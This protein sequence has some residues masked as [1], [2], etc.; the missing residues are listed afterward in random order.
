MTITTAIILNAILM[1]GII[2][3]LAR[4]IHLPFRIE[5]RLPKLD[6][7]VYVPGRDEEEELSRAA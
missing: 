4:F 7:A 2:V 3:A 5:K 6:H 1:A